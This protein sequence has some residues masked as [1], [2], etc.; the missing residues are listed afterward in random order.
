VK[1]KYKCLQ[2]SHWPY[3]RKALVTI[4]LKQGYE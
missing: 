2:F 1:M 4:S 3:L